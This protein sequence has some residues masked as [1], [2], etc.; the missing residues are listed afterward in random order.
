[1]VT[2]V[3]IMVIVTALS[4]AVSQMVRKL[5]VRQGNERI[6]CKMILLLCVTAIVTSL[7]M[8]SGKFCP[9]RLMLEIQMSLAAMYMLKFSKNSESDRRLS[10]WLFPGMQLLMAVYYVMSLAGFVPMPS[11][12][13]CLAIADLIAML[14]LIMFVLEIWSKLRDVKYLMKSGNPWSFLNICVDAVYAILPLA[15]LML[16]HALCTLFPSL[17]GAAALSAAVALY[18][19]VLAIAVRISSDSA[20]AFLRNHERIIVESMKISNVDAAT[21]PDVKREKQYKEL[22]DR[23]AAYF[24]TCRP[25]LD[26]NLT[27]SDVAKIVYSN[28][29]YISKAICHFTGHN[30]RQYVN[31]HRIMYSIDL[32]RENLEFKVSEL[33]ERSG[34]NNV[35]TYTM[36]F[37]L[38]MGETPS[39]WCRKERSKILKP[40]K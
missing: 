24:E 16:L 21:A 23:I 28:K 36:A 20:F 30:F 33:A 7:G 9:F 40:K 39:D 32:F 14:S 37:R 34:F 13:V 1:M 26:G 31:Y 2:T 29:V 8:I 25:Y 27:I 12:K 4:F 19:E 35:V 3:S 6:A 17:S 11:D 15:V 18:L 38:F 10:Q 5:K 22:Y